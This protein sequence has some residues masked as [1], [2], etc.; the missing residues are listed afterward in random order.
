MD[1]S[2]DVTLSYLYVHDRTCGSYRFIIL[3]KL[4]QVLRSDCHLRLN[5]LSFLAA[6]FTVVY[7][8]NIWVALHDSARIIKFRNKHVVSPLQAATHVRTRLR[9]QTHLERVHAI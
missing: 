4:Q 3:E 9:S 8:S 1:V 6:V 2:F 5:W 7:C